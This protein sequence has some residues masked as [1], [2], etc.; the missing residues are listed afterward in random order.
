MN[1]DTI[2]L[3]TL[4]TE[5]RQTYYQGMGLYTYFLYLTA[6]LCQELHIA[7]GANVEFF[8]MGRANLLRK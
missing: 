4:L 6:P 1:Y 3:E 2:I 7:V 5:K 8:A